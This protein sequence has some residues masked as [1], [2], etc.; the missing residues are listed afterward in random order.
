MS[1]IIL[2]SAELTHKFNNAKFIAISSPKLKVTRSNRVGRTNSNTL[3]Y[4][5]VSEYLFIRFQCVSSYFTNPYGGFVGDG[6]SPGRV[7]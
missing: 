2:Q 1:A 6:I 3:Q 4:T 5:L 7:G